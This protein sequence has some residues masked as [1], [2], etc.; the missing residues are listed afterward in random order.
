MAVVDTSKQETRRIRGEIEQMFGNVPSWVDELP[1]SALAGFWTTMRDFQLGETR[2]PNKYK[3]LIGLG[4]S[5]A[6]RCRYCALFHTEAAK[7]FGATDEEI[8]EAAMMAAHTMSASTFMN[9][10]QTD[11]DA[12]RRETLDAIS[13]VRSHAAG[14]SSPQPSQPSPNLH[15]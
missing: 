4:V 12:F 6:T 7:L 3:E 15:A 1:E 9:A 2:I 13:Y 5:G 11:Y 8:A 10:M 14:A